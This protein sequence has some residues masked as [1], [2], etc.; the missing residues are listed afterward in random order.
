ML[1]N[2]PTDNLYK[3]FTFLGVALII[4]SAWTY[5]ENTRKIE[6]A[7]LTAEFEL[8]S[9]K[10]QAAILEGEVKGAEN[11][12]T[13]LHRQLQDPATRPD[14]DSTEFARIESRV[15]QLQIK[16]EESQKSLASIKQSNAD[17]RAK[18]NNAQTTAKSLDSQNVILIISFS[19]GLAMALVGFILWYFM[20]QK[21]QDEILKRSTQNPID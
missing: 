16:K 1:Q 11:E 5:I 14:P 17:L 7:I 13:M 10:S 18:I 19:I 15:E 4:F 8:Q 20:H 2:P 6:V 3:F 9:L 12:A 21:Y